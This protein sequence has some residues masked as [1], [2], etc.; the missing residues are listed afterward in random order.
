MQAPRSWKI[1]Q[2]RPGLTKCRTSLV[3]A[4]VRRDAGLPPTAPM[5]G[6]M[7]PTR[8]RGQPFSLISAAIETTAC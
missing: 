6:G 4:P 2:R 8:G 5:G 1:L 3:E 7:A